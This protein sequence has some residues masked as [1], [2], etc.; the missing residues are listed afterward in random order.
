MNSLVFFEIILVLVCLLVVVKIKP[1]MTLSRLFWS[2]G[3]FSIAV[4]ALL[5]AFKYAGFEQLAVYHAS[6]TGFA[7]SMGLISLTIGGLLGALPRAILT[8]GPLWYALHGAVAFG[9]VF[10]G[11]GPKS[12]ALQYGAVGILLVLGIYDLAKGEREAGLYM[13]GGIGCFIIASVASE[14]ISSIMGVDM[15]NIFHAL[16][17][18]A[19]FLMGAAVLKK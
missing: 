8:P 2:A 4:A 6:A 13:I 19:V 3:F 16:L 11:G 15:R 5:G 9:A 10:M 18:A 14:P 1:A 12:Q 17:A 7:G